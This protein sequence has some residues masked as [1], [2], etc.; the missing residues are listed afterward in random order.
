[1]QEIRYD[2]SQRITMG[3]KPADFL[4]AAGDQNNKTVALHNAPP[5]GS[6]IEGQTV[7]DGNRH[8]LALKKDGRWAWNMMRADGSNA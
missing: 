6:I 2:G 4:R 7:T 8:L 5:V 1:M 3:P